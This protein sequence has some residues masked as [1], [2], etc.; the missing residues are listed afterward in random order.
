MIH[1]SAHRLRRQSLF[2]RQSSVEIT[3]QPSSSQLPF[4]VCRKRRNESASTSRRGKIIGET[5]A[6]SWTD[7]H[8]LAPSRR[9]AVFKSHCFACKPEKGVKKSDRDNEPSVSKSILFRIFNAVAVANPY[10][11][12]NIQGAS[13]NKP[14]IGTEA[15]KITADSRSVST[16]SR[17]LRRRTLAPP[18][19]GCAK[20]GRRRIGSCLLGGGSLGYAGD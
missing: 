4:A 7:K 8:S 18:S 16:P 10:N 6:V 5:V 1:A 12:S 15:L 13:T 17:H 2:K 3:W 19:F 20:H 9:G 14:A 11:G